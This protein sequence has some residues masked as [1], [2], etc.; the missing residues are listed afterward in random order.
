MLLSRASAFAS[1]SS[2]PASPQ[3]SADAGVGKMADMEDRFGA[4]APFTIGV[5]EE[6]QLVDPSTRELAPAIEDVIGATSIG[7]GAKNLPLAY[8]TTLDLL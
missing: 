1:T 5:E 3:A 2:S 8:H 6:F 7:V 4:S